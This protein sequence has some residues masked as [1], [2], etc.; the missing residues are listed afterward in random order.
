MPG[1]SS[2]PMSL[3]CGTPVTSRLR[4]G[5]PTPAA[6]SLDNLPGVLAPAAS[7]HPEPEP[8][9]S[10]SGEFVEPEIDADLFSRTDEL[11]R[12]H[13]EMAEVDLT[14]PFDV[15]GSLAVIEKHLQAL[16]DR[17]DDVVGRLQ[18]IRA[19]VIRHYREGPETARDQPA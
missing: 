9:P 15:A 3:S 13:D 19:A 5:A 4:A 6:D 16:T 18:E 11:L 12:A 8:A 1:R 10:Q 17:Q 14:S 7:E 2:R